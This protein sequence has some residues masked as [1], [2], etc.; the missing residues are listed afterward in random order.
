MANCVK[1]IKKQGLIYL[2]QTSTK[3]R[4]SETSEKMP[5]ESTDKN[6]TTRTPQTLIESPI[7]YIVLENLKIN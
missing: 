6:K 4:Y 3:H 2:A 5:T 7:I 1:L